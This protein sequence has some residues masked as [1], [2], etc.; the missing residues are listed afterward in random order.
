MHISTV[1]AAGGKVSLR[2]E[3]Q[4]VFVVGE[5]DQMSPRDFMAGFL[6]IVHNM[7]LGEDLMEVRVDVTGLAFLN[8]SGIKEFLSWILRRNRLPP[9]KKYK[10]N[11]LF[12]PAVAW[13]PI[14]LPRLRD[15]DPS[16]ILLTAQPQQQ[17]AMLAV[18]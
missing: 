5:I 16:G 2:V 8:S 10:I 4:T 1:Q 17:M 6:E 18:H 15:L 11:F 3:G 14:T 12:N 9:E 13:Q 7:V